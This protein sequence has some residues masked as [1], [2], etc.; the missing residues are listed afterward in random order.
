MR[1]ARRV[2]GAQRPPLQSR[3]G[4]GPA[5]LVGASD[6]GG[7]WALGRETHTCYAPASAWGP[8]LFHLGPSVQVVALGP[9]P[10]SSAEVRDWAGMPLA[11][12]FLQAVSPP[13]LRALLGPP[14]PHTL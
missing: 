6:V 10:E 7:C 4:P 12:G 3:L 9:S 13:E 14:P 2:R 1:G 5:L 11:Q 8:G